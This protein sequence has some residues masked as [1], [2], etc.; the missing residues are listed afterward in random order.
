MSPWEPSMPGWALVDRDS[1]RTGKETWGTPE[2]HVTNLKNL[3]QVSHA[4]NCPTGPVVYLCCCVIQK[5]KRHKYQLI[6]SF[7]RASKEEARP[8]P[9]CLTLSKAKSPLHWWPRAFQ[10]DRCKYLFTDLQSVD[11]EIRL[12][13]NQRQNVADIFSI[14]IHKLAP[15]SGLMLTA[16]VKYPLYLVG[17]VGFHPHTLS[18]GQVAANQLIAKTKPFSLEHTIKN[19]NHFIGLIW[20]I[21]VKIQ[22]S[23]FKNVNEI[24]LFF[25]K[26]QNI[27]TGG[28]LIANGWSPNEEGFFPPQPN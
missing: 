18:W 10:L 26:Y 25:F 14:Y 9:C 24:L 11:D 23:L 3:W 20:K 12:Q 16:R 19:S 6:I 21:T 8:P 5:D 22:R 17:T 4:L 28:L 7:K 15:L 13:N 27:N 1:K 2:T